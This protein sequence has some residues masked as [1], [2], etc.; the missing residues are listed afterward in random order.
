ME[1]DD[2]ISEDRVREAIRYTYGTVSVN[3]HY[4]GSKVKRF[5]DSCHDYDHT[6]VGEYITV[7]A[8]KFEANVKL[9]SNTEQTLMHMLRI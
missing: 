9:D 1:N 8:V 3:E 4:I 7:G 2:I 5:L 6:T